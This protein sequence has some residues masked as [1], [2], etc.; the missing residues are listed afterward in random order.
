M[1]N[2]SGNY[3]NWVE[4][5]EKNVK[6]GEILANVIGLSDNIA[7]ALPVSGLHSCSLYTAQ[8][9]DDAGATMRF[10]AGLNLSS[11]C[12]APVVPSLSTP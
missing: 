10:V 5:E 9:A 12:G 8:R 1:R 4:F 2:Y 6:T 7:V 3:C 11:F